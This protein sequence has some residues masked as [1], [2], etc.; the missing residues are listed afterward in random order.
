MCAYPPLHTTPPLDNLCNKIMQ[1]FTVEETEGEEESYHANESGGS[2]TVARFEREIRLLEKVEPANLRVSY[3]Y[4][5][6]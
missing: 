6:L 3:H 4:Y 2:G 1:G 5:L